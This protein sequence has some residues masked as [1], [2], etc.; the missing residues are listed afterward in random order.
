M[1]VTPAELN[2][3][4]DRTWT[5]EADATHFLAR[6]EH[7]PWFLDVGKT[8]KENA[9]EVWIRALWYQMVH[10]EM[11]GF[12]KVCRKALEQKR[13]NMLTA[14][15]AQPSPL[16]RCYE[17]VA[18]VYGI[19]S[20]HL[21][22]QLGPFFAAHIDCAV[23]LLTGGSWVDAPVV[24]AKASVAVTSTGLPENFLIDLTNDLS[25]IPP[26]LAQHQESVGILLVDSRKNE[27]FMATLVYE[28]IPTDGPGVLYPAPSVSLIYRDPTF[29]NA[30]TV[31]WK[32]FESMRS[33]FGDPRRRFDVRWS[34]KR[35]P[36][37]TLPWAISGPSASA[38][39]GMLSELVAA[40]T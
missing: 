31:A 29:I 21:H 9:R 25:G 36:P 5:S 13:S 12:F 37:D 30:E 18:R 16:D 6:E 1:F 15:S 26:T 10:P 17:E 19:D 22:G 33:K 4:L 20:K 34:L 39:Q 8:P 24:G 7:Q 3:L 2:A 38:A 40:R 28:A 27:G 32:H 23:A 11:R 35:R 14:W